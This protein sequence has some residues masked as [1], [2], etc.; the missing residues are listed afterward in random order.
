VKP[1]HVPATQSSL[2]G[3]S[4]AFRQAG[5]R[6]KPIGQDAEGTQDVVKPALTADGRRQHTVPLAQSPTSRHARAEYVTPPAALVSHAEP[7]VHISEAV[8]PAG[9]ATQ[10]TWPLAHAP[11]PHDTPPEVPLSTQAPRTLASPGALE[12]LVPVPVSIVVVV[13]GPAST[14]GAA[15]SRAGSIVDSPSVPPPSS[16][17]SVSSPHADAHWLAF[18]IASPRQTIWTHVSPDVHPTPMQS[19]RISM[20]RVS[21]V[22]GTKESSRRATMQPA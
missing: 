3:H 14:I 1:P 4:Q 20:G 8:P 17:G 15:A 2:A 11:V 19:A 22:C 9:Q 16:R 12:S 5:R 18:V 13:S 7:L 21:G 6:V 10:Q